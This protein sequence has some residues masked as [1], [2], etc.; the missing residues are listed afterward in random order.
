MFSV[1]SEDE[2]MNQTTQTPSHTAITAT[3]IAAKRSIRS[4]VVSISDSSLKIILNNVSPTVRLALST[5]LLLISDSLPVTAELTKQ[6]IIENNKQVQ[7][8]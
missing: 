6:C 7:F 8:R 5:P 3:H 2:N 1:L 4:N